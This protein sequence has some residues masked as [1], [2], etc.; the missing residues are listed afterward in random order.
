MTL[1]RARALNRATLERQLLLRRWEL[2]VPQA[3]ERLVGLQA[4]TPHTWY[5][6]LWTR[7]ADYRPEPTADLLREAG[8]V[9]MAL[10]RSTIHLV[11]A[12][13]CLWLRPLVEPVIE[14][15]TAGSFGRD[16]VGLDRT[17]LAAAGRELLGDEPLTFSELGR[18]L[19]ERW[20][21][22]DPAALAQA[23]R[24]SVPLVQVPPRGLWGR[25][26]R[27]AHTP[28]EA[29]LG[30][31][32]D[33]A[34]DVRQLVLRH[35]AAFGPATVRDVQ[36]WSGLTRLAEVIDG[37]RPQLMVFRDEQGRELYD[38]P[39]APRPHPDT[40]APVRFLYDFDN[41][42][43]SHAD[44]SRVLTVSFADQGFAGTMEMPR[45]VLV[46]GFVAA[47]W[48]VVAKRGEATL[49]VRPFRRLT[50]AEREEIVAEGTRLLAF[51][52]AKATARD[53]VFEAPQPG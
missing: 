21:D 17:D 20:P 39:D 22:R 29:W 37:L 11:T 43:L 8:V 38:L 23:V 44:R 18:A 27:A 26:G 34:A 41:L 12:A 47:T 51:A 5:V 3:L 28:V 14:R 16:L 6:G 42:L 53:I 48:K 4:Q 24:A 1:L 25:S 52:A 32:V 46:D 31:P 40:P 36:Q 45:A 50:A 15:S 49:T 33:T 9:R 35:L 10:M 13:D 19:A 2:T 7:L 30:R